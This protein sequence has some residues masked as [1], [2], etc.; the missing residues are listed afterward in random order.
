[1]EEKTE[2]LQNAKPFKIGLSIAQIS[3]IVIVFSILKQVLYYK[4]FN[5]PIESFLDLSGL[6]LIISADLVILFPIVLFWLLLWGGMFY[7]A[8]YNEKKWAIKRQEKDY[9]EKIKKAKSSKKLWDRMI[10]MLVIAMCLP[11]LLVLYELFFEKNFY[12]MKIKNIGTFVILIT[13]ALVIM[14][15]LNNLT[16]PPASII[17]TLS[18]VG[19]FIGIFFDKLGR[20]IAHAEYGRFK[21][22]EI[23]VGEKPPLI[24]NDSTYF[25]GKTDKYFFIYD[26]HSNSTTI[27]PSETVTKIVLKKNW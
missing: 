11:V 2:S 1:M 19:F 7:Y 18:T 26:K 13:F 27:L 20:E 4:N 15:L 3:A 6:G 8:S 9:I 14:I 16:K 24:S 12:Y 23:Y 17:I 25:I 22:T 21:G 5:V 10:V